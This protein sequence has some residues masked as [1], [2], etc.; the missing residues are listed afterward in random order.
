MLTVGFVG[1][2]AVVHLLYAATLRGRAAY[3]VRYV[4][5]ISP[6]QAE[7][8]A[9]LFGADVVPID[10]LIER[11]GAVVLTTPPDTHAALL[12]QCLRPGKIVLCEKPFTTSY[13][14]ALEISREAAAAGAR[15]YVGHFRRTFP[16]LRLARSLIQ[17]GVIGDVSDIFVSEGGRFTWK[18]VSDYTVKHPSG[19]VLWDTAPHSL[20]MALFGAGLD[21]WSD[22]DVTLLDVGR[23]KPEPS[24]DFRARFLIDGGQ[25]RRHITGRVHVTRKEVLPNFIRLSGARGSVAFSVGMDRHVRLTTPAGSVV[26]TS[27]DQ[28]ADLMECFDLQIRRIFLNQQDQDFSS[29]RFLALTKILEALANG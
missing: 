6:R 10:E 5:D 13:R 24:H 8:A 4:S 26:L 17:L 16:Q 27:E 12:R 23:D 15:L 11:S 9:Q 22:C 20:D 3:A 28:H 7:S 2:G 19:G 1:C 21:D 25:P 18:A 14:D 29:H